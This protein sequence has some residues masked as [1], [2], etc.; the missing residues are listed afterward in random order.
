MKCPTRVLACS[1]LCQ[2]RAVPGPEGSVLHQRSCNDAEGTSTGQHMGWKPDGC[3]HLDFSQSYGEGSQSCCYISA[4][5]PYYLSFE[6]A[7]YFFICV[8]QS[9]KNGQLNL[10]IRLA[11]FSNLLQ[12]K[13]NFGGEGKSLKKTLK[14]FFPLIQT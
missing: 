1:C 9:N 2:A 12:L 3:C 7:A 6:S 11:E 13:Q 8:S 4:S 10:F 14:L 5:L